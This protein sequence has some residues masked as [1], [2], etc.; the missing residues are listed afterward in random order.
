MICYIKR[1]LDRCI[2]LS[3]LEFVAEVVGVV[4]PSIVGHVFIE[5]L[6]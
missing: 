5:L 1:L 2:I 4:S 6:T 3:L